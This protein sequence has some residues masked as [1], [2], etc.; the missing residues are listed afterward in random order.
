MFLQEPVRVV[1]EK[2]SRPIGCRHKRR[3]AE[4][5]NTMVY[6]PLLNTLQHLLNND[7]LVAEAK[8]PVLVMCSA[9]MALQQL[10]STMEW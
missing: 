4:I 7:A 1:L 3:V 9:C 10:I 8:Q 5:E 6:I 2:E